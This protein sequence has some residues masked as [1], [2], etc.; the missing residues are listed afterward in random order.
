M[1]QRQ[2]FSNG[3]AETVAARRA[4]VG[5][6]LA[7]GNGVREIARETGSSLISVHR[8][9]HQGALAVSVAGVWVAADC[10]SVPVDSHEIGPV[11]MGVGF[12]GVRVE[13]A[14]AAAHGLSSAHKSVAA[15]PPR[16][17]SRA[18]SAH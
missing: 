18:R 13:G 8:A 16:W 1:R 9:E 6:L 10:Q 14:Q 4:Q 11:T 7:A 17:L 12:S 15:C 5:L 2:V 3:M